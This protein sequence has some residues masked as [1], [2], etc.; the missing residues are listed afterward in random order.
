MLEAVVAVL[1]IFAVVSAFC[2]GL[3]YGATENYLLK[4]DI[5][6]LE[7]GISRERALRIRTEKPCSR[8]GL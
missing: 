6:R 7:I 5:Q 3:R 4:K 2:L 8:N 1:L